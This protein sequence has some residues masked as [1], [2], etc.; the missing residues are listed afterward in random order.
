MS[1]FFLSLREVGHVLFELLAV[2]AH[3]A[4]DGNE[5]RFVE[6]AVRRVAA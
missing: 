4:Q 3:F 5:E 6:A 1:A 2:E